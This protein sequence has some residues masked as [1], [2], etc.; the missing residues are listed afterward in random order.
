MST[1]D[2]VSE[3]AVAA[4]RWTPAERVRLT[5]ILGVVT[6]LHVAGVSLYLAYQGDIAGA[7]GVAGAGALAYVL[8]MRHAFDAD[9]IAAID[10]T[11]RVML[12][13]GRRPVGV[14][15]FFAMGHSTVV[16]VLALVVAA[17]AGSL[18]QAGVDSLRS[19]G[20][21]VAVVVAMLF[22]LV[23]ASLN[24]RVLGTLVRLWRRLRSGVDA[25]DEVEH[26]LL[27]RGVLNRLLGGRIRGLIQHSW[28]MYPVGLLMGLGLETASEVTLLA[29][30]ASSAAGGRLPLTAVLSLP[31]L[32]AAGMS[33]F[34]TADSLVMTRIYSW[35]YREP[36]R[37]LLFNIATTAMT[38]LIAGFV[39]VVYLAGALVDYGGVEALAPL[40]AVGDDFEL[41][42]YGIA[43]AFVLTWLAAFGVWRWSA[44]E[45]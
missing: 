26:A 35:S 15:F 6:A 18:S 12:L 36:A 23:V 45:R 5:A 24:A 34:D 25:A 4:G 40:A 13:R 33:M 28:H 20:G 10:D 43:G 21:A 32:F 17:A 7:G 31:L 19:I 44:R 2:A 1:H 9:H 16:V 30:S 3:R 38:V 22:L 29:L 11:T 27:S 37:T 14:G 8:G 41:L 39:A 42:G